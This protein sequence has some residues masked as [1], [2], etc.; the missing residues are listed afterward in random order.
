MKLRTLFLTTSMIVAAGSP[1]AV[2]DITVTRA[3]ISNGFVI[4]TGKAA[5]K[6]TI[7]LDG[8]VAQRKASASGA[9]SFGPLPYVPSSCIAMLTSPGQ[10]TVLASVSNCGPISLD[11]QGAWNSEQTYLTDQLVFQGGS[12]WRAMIP[13]PAGVTPGTDSGQYWQ[14]FATAEGA[15]GAAG[16]T[17]ATGP[18]GPIGA[19]GATGGSGTAGATGATGDAGPT[20]P[21]GATGDMGATGATGNTGATGATGAVGPTGPTGE[22]G[23]TGATGNAGPLGPTGDTGATGATGPTGPTGVSGAT[24]PTGNTGP[25]GPTGPGLSIQEV[26]EVSRLAS[27]G[28]FEPGNSLTVSIGPQGTALVLLN[29]KIQ[30][31]SGSITTC[32]LGLDVA[33]AFN[34]YSPSSLPTVSLLQ[35]AAIVSEL[36]GS[37]AIYVTGLQPFSPVVFTLN[38]KADL[39]FC[40]FVSSQ[41][42]IMPQ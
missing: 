26:S 35:D 29:T 38:Y 25:T 3:T 10:S 28:N 7:T 21:A 24:G 34:S 14:L 8:G 33:S 12:T 9:F 1:A 27:S 5:P 36:T 41:A 18:A 2:A 6:S 39:G 4:I 37:T 13:V 42:I 15:T 22:T 31:N 40:N 17:G 19:T 30:T 20:G 11:P 23:A 16:P 32:V